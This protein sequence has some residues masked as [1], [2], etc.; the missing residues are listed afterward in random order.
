M[1]YLYN[2]QNQE[3][4]KK[5]KD[6]KLNK[7]EEKQIINNFLKANKINPLKCLL[8]KK[9][10]DDDQS[11]FGKKYIKT[12]VYIV[13]LFFILLIIGIYSIQFLNNGLADG[14]ETSEKIIFALMALVFHIVLLTIF[15]LIFNIDIILKKNILNKLRK[16]L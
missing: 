12:L 6:F 4:I 15:I 2:E 9:E 3:L 13:S 7:Q 14:L 1:K 16:N 11:E 10:A 8:D 5:L